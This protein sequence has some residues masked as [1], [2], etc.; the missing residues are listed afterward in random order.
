VT[1]R[2]TATSSRSLE[3]PRAGGFP[4]QD[5]I[6]YVSRESIREV[7]TWSFGLPAS[8][9]PA[10]TQPAETLVAQSA[11]PHSLPREIGVAGLK[12]ADDEV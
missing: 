8:E 3:P 10:I 6:L 1:V 4:P 9:E 2:P 12:G 5:G 7:A 11:A